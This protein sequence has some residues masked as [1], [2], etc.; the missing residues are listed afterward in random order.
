MNYKIN[1]GDKFGKLTVLGQT[2]LHSNKLWEFKC[3]CGTLCTKNVYSVIYGNTKSCGCLAKEVLLKRNTKHNMS[4]SREYAAWRRITN[5]IYNVNCLDYDAYGGRGLLCDYKDN[6]TGFLKEIGPYPDDGIQ[7]SVDR[8]DNNKGYVEGNIRW[9]TNEQQARNKGKFKNNSSG[10]T[11]VYFTERPRTN[12]NTTYAVAKCI[13]LDGR[14]QSKLFSTRK[15][16]ILPAFAM[17]VR[18]REKMI[19]NLNKLGAEYSPIH[20]E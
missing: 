1:K 9:A 13:L 16:G 10:V 2:E 20:G 15:Y 7:Y 18:Y 4:N 11:G 8:I 6:F 5:R 3:E 12:Y 19:D 17:A 14:V